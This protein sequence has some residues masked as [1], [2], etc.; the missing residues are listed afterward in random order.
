MYFV[1]VHSF[2]D[3]FRTTKQPGLSFKFTIRHH[4]PS[5]SPDFI[6]ILFAGWVTKQQSTRN[7][8][9]EHLTAK[10]VSGMIYG[11]IMSNFQIAAKEV[12]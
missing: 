10:A 11:R 6:G 4:C 1:I 8:E 7:R 12:S 9:K 5:V 2:F 3:I